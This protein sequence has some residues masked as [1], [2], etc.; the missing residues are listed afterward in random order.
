MAVSVVFVRRSPG[1]GQGPKRAERGGDV[2]DRLKRIRE[3]RAAAA[4]FPGEVFHGQSKNAHAQGGPTEAQFFVLFHELRSVPADERVTRGFDLNGRV[5][6]MKAL[7]QEG[8]RLLQQN[9]LI[10]RTCLAHKM[11]R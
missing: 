8:Q 5:V 3:E 6:D 1:N 10:H 2:D 11:N 9:V 4:E 7:V